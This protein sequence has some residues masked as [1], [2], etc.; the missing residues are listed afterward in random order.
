MG[1]CAISHFAKHIV[2][3]NS[4]IVNG[5]FNLHRDRSGN[6]VGNT[7]VHAKR[8]G[9]ESMDTRG[10]HGDGDGIQVLTRNLNTIHIPLICIGTHSCIICYIHAGEGT[11][12]DGIKCNSKNRL[13]CDSRQNHNLEGVR[14]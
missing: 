2:T 7:A 13:H 6:A 8:S 5:I 1:E 10:C 12:A 3:R 11:Y 4:N 14:A 9:S